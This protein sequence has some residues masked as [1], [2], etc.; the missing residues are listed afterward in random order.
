MLGGGGATAS[1]SPYQRGPWLL[2]KIHPRLD[3]MNLLQLPFHILF[4]FKLYLVN[5][6]NLVN[7][8]DLTTMFTKSRL[9]YTINT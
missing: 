1:L 2:L 6:L 5:R 4:L 9:E 3:F 7:K 8:M